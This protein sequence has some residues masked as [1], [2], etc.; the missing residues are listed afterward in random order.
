MPI[1]AGGHTMTI[2]TKLA[3]GEQCN[4]YRCSIDGGQ[5]G[6][7][8]IARK[9]E[10][11]PLLWRESEVL[12]S[13]L[14]QD[15]SGH[16]SPF[17]PRVQAQVSYTH[18]TAEPPR[19]ANVLA[20]HAEINHPDEL[21]SLEEV[22]AA[23]PAGADARDV[24]WMW[25]R[26]LTVLSFIH[27]AR[28]VHGAVSPSHILIEP[29][30]HKLVL[31]GWCG[32]VMIGEA[33]ITRPARFRDWADWTEKAMPSVDLACAAKSMLY[34]LAKPADQAIARHFER[35]A[36]VQDADKLLSDFDRMIDA[37]WGQ[38]RFREFI[39]PERLQFERT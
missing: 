14:D 36:T 35:A 9:A 28:V 29:R 23:Y 21:Y 7:F 20:Y 25:R 26:L 24:A 27:R 31:V 17:L 16:Y 4:L 5:T 18:S 2:L 11:N 37:M 13:L 38:R 39:M 10:A 8:K 30:E 6:V 33:P 15:S 3:T 19:C 12:S 34:L 1:K 32:A 22:A